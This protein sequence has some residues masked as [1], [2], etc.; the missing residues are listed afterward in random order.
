[1]DTRADRAAAVLKWLFILGLLTGSVGACGGDD[2]GTCI[3]M[4]SGDDVVIEDISLEECQ[5]RFLEE[6][7]ARGVEWSPNS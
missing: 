2:L 6:P 3:I 5:Q 4:K 7:G 1:M